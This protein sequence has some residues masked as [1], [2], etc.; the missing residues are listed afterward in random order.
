MGWNVTC[1]DFG[2]SGFGNCSASNYWKVKIDNN[3][4]NKSPAIGLKAFEL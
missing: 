2:F 4:I 1:L 3:I